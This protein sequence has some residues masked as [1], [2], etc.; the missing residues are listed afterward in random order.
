MG[1]YL[2]SALPVSN[3]IYVK[4]FVVD[5]VHANLFIYMCL[6]SRHAKQRF[7]A[8]TPKNSSKLCLAA[9]NLVEVLTQ[10]LY[11]FPY[12]NPYLSSKCLY[13]GANI[14]ASAHVITETEGGAGTE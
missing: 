3:L 11:K 2:L 12:T 9:K 6:L 13:I 1:V 7:S 14:H 8:Y 10:S 4:M 5:E